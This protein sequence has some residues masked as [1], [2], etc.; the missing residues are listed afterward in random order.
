MAFLSTQTRTRTPPILDFFLP[1]GQHVVTYLYVGIPSCAVP[2]EV[3]PVLPAE[4]APHTPIPEAPPF[5]SFD[6]S[7]HIFGSLEPNT[8]LDR[9][10][11]LSHEEIANLTRSFPDGSVGAGNNTDLSF[12]A[13]GN[14]PAPLFDGPGPQHFQLQPQGDEYDWTESGTVFQPPAGHQ[15]TLSTPTRTAYTAPECRVRT[16]TPSVRAE[17]M[18]RASMGYQPYP[19]PALLGSVGHPHPRSFVRS[20]S[21][22]LHVGI[23][24]GPATSTLLFTSTPNSPTLGAHQALRTLDVANE[25]DQQGM[26]SRPGTPAVTRSGTPFAPRPQ[27]TLPNTP[28]APTTYHAAGGGEID[29]WDEDLEELPAPVG[30]DVPRRRVPLP[31]PSRNR[32]EVPSE[33]VDSS[34]GFLVN[35]DDLPYSPIPATLIAPINSNAPT[36]LE[37][38]MNRGE[39]VRKLMVV[40]KYKDTGNGKTSKGAAALGSFSDEAQSY[41][42]VMKA[43]LLW[44]LLTRSP[45]SEMDK[46]LIERAVKYSDKCTNLLGSTIVTDEFK[47]TVSLPFA[48]KVPY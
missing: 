29:T 48:I 3:P 35:L 14:F 30:Q 15:Q 13:I 20:V 24:R 5:V 34:D 45:W 27:L 47:K 2:Y 21:S 33:A 7:S 10:P 40:R 37:I 19:S 46:D 42:S 32:V 18:R 4:P 26:V 28:L 44:D 36:M 9:L 17:T 25:W 22:P 38:E 41:L 39:E 11:D 16:P 23:G 43:C 6:N 12:N 31:Q 1:N 8:T